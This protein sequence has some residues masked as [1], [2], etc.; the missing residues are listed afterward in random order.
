[1]DGAVLKQR[2]KRTLVTSTLACALALAAVAAP[3][4]SLRPY[5]PEPVDFELAAPGAPPLRA[6]ATAGFVSPV[7]RAPR[8]FNLAGL[9]WSGRAAP[10]IAI[11]VRRTGGRWSAW[12]PVAGHPD[13]GPDPTRGEPAGRS[14]SSP[15]WA[16][17][18]DELQYRLSRPVARLRLHFVNTTGSSTRLARMSTALRASTAGALVAVAA[19]VQPARAQSPV[20]AIVPRSAWGAA[21]C[22]PRA[23]ASYGE[24]KAAFVHHT[25]TA[26][27]YTPEQ[28]PAAVLAICRYHRNANRWTDVGYNFLVDKYGTIYEGRAGGVG[29]AVLGA[30]AQGFN[31]QTTGIANIGTHSALP[32]TDAALDSIARLIRWK[33]P[34]H[35]QPTAGTVPVTSAGG[36]SNRFGRGQEVTLERISGHRDGNSTSCPGEALYAQLPN[37]R[38]RVGGVAPVTPRTRI[39]ATVGPGVVRFPQQARLTGTL[40]MLTGAGVG[41]APVEVQAFAGRAGW[42]TVA[43]TTSAAG[44][45]FE[46][47]LSPPA[48]RVLRARF[49]GGQGL[50]GSTSRQGTVLVRP[51]LTTTRSVSRAQVGRTPVIAGTIG[52]AKKRVLVVVERRIGGRNRRVGRVLVPARGGRFRTAFRLRQSGLHRFSA[53][54]AGDAANLPAS[55][56]PVYVRAL[57]TAGGGASRR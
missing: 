19:L 33:L 5:R 37:L 2:M 48:K 36:A 10:R 52:P 39:E 42:R 12:T 22:A 30:Q 23:A 24:V 41:G 7:V 1:M 28:A 56:V 3:A 15:L 18:A 26:N 11:R 43:R 44:G 34:L 17:E 13:G 21:D 35:G 54:F 9:R 53:V 6:A 47:L 49:P 46:A 20:P 14:V 40:R 16:G 25:V 51:T 57:G 4:L 8:R 31:A 50:L 38:A 45:A 29:R 32:Q 55:G 27:D